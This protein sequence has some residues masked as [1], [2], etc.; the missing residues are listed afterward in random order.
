M[1]HWA[2]LITSNVE[3]YRTPQVTCTIGQLRLSPCL[4]VGMSIVIL[5]Q[6]I[7]DNDEGEV[8][9]QTM[10]WMSSGFFSSTA[11]TTIKLT[12]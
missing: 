10:M 9:T 7:I 1:R 11:N 3:K 5:T 4:R 6:I 2:S 8:R 12:G